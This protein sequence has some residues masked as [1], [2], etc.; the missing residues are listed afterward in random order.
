VLSSSIVVTHIDS[1]HSVYG[2]LS[3]FSLYSIYDLITAAR[4]D[5]TD[6]HSVIIL[7]WE[8]ST[9]ASIFITPSEVFVAKKLLNLLSKSVSHSKSGIESMRRIICSA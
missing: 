1:N 7:D 3:P 4:F 8:A 5:A 2:T 9:K 6:S